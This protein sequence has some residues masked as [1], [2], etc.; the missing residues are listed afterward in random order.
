LL[1]SEFLICFIVPPAHSRHIFSSI[2]F[3]YWWP[4]EYCTT[5]QLQAIQKCFR[6]VQS[7]SSRVDT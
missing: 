4:H 5:L 2:E 6:V 3:Y 7:Q 1:S